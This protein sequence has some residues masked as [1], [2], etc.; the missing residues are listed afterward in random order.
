MNSTLKSLLFW[1]V[2]VVVG[3]LIWN[4]STKFQTPQHQAN[5]SQFMQSVDANQ[6]QRVIISGQDIVFFTKSSERFTTYAPSQFDGLVNKLIERGI[7]VSAKE[8]TASPWASLLY[9][10][11]PVLLMVGFWIF[12]MRKMQSGGNK[13]L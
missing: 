12:F 2:L 9:S 13:A 3:V 1:M 10:W 4:V 5:F 7:D 11:A 8:P 6:V